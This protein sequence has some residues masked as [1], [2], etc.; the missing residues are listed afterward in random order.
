M[1]WVFTV[2]RVFQA[3]SFTGSVPVAAF[4]SE[5]DAKRFVNELVAATGQMLQANVVFLQPTGASQAFGTLGQILKD[6]GIAQIAY[7]VS[8]MD[9]E[10]MIKCPEKKILMPS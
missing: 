4:D 7:A 3:K 8:A 10:G 1:S 6:L 9:I 2:Y 5:L